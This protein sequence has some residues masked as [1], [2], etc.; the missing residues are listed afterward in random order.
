[1]Y[2]ANLFIAFDLSR[3]VQDIQN[4]ASELSQNATA[5]SDLIRARAVAQ[6]QAVVEGAHSEGLALMFSRLNITSQEQK[7]SL[8]YLRTLRDHQQVYMSIN[9]DSLVNTA[10]FN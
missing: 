8:N 3:K 5:Q 10:G 4:Q 2:H 6:A 9:F 1:M 7:A